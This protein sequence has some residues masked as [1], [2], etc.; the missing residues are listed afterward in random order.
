MK[1]LI[2]LL[3][4]A[5]RAYSFCDH[6]ITLGNATIQ[7]Q[8]NLQVIQQSYTIRREDPSNG[9]CSR[10]RLYFS[11]GIANSYQREAANSTGVRADYNLHQN[12]QMAGT[13]KDINDA[14]SSTEYIAGNTPDE[15]TDYTG[16]FYI[17]V[18]GFISQGSL[19]GGTYTDNI[20]I[21]VFSLDN[22]SNMEPEE[23]QPFSVNL[24][25]NTTMEISLVDEGG[26]HNASS[27]AKI[28]NFGNLATN[29]EM[30]A[31]ITVSS[32]TAYQVRLSSLN[33]GNLK[34][35]TQTLA[36]Q[37]RVNNTTYSM[38]SS[39]GTPVSV[40]TGSAT[41]TNPARYNVKVKITGATTSL[42]AGDYEDTITITAIAN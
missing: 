20:Q 22:N 27:T 33:N 5:G 2:L 12:I 13:L 9:R 41:G 15:K 26:I 39:A 21:R 40:A 8:N 18:P 32:N 19:P 23:V 34:R 17:S 10:Y 16:S 29:Q 7:I 4:V 42:V 31:D 11:K 25:A 3:L 6:T 28:L 30:G 38:T 14:N 36:Y 35:G 37:L 1:F 24:L